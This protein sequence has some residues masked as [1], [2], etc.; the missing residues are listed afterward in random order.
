MKARAITV[1]AAGIAIVAFLG[2]AHASAAPDDQSGNTDQSANNDQIEYNDQFVN[3]VRLDGIA[4]TR[5][6]VMRDGLEAC[7]K[8]KEG[9]NGPQTAEYIAKKRGLDTDDSNQFV[10]D[11]VRY[12]CPEY[13]EPLTHQ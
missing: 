10:L 7:Q 1:G 9:K 8:V 11:A 4:G 6:T 13:L 2:A 3:K 5:D 12:L